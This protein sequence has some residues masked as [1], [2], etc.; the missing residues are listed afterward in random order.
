MYRCDVCKNWGVRPLKHSHIEI[1][2]SG[3]LE[4]IDLKRTLHTELSETIELDKGTI[5]Y[6]YFQMKSD[7][8]IIS[9][10]Q[11][12]ASRTHCLCHN[13]LL[14]SLSFV[15]HYGDGAYCTTNEHLKVEHPRVIHSH[16][17]NIREMNYRAVL[18][19]KDATTFTKIE[20][21]AGVVKN[22][23]IGEQFFLSDLVFTADN[24]IKII[25]FQEWDGLSWNDI[26]L[27]D[28]KGVS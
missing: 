14:Y 6:R 22:I 16:G 23:P 5:L 1:G 9:S 7:I 17:I 28:L 3:L 21:T 12:I 4:E 13:C 27:D 20:K 19:L 8:S 26:L 11:K 10:S 2:L 18:R 24:V 25:G 15:P